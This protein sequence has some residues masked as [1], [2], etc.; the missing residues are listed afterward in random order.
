MIIIPN[1]WLSCSIWLIDG[2]LTGITTIRMDLRVMVMKGY[3]TFSKRWNLTIRRCLAPCSRHSGAGGTSVQRC[4]QPIIKA[5]V[6][7]AVDKTLIWNEK[8]F[9]C[10]YMWIRMFLQWKRHLWKENLWDHVVYCLFLC[11]C[12][13][14]YY[15]VIHS[16]RV[17]L[18]FF[19]TEQTKHRISNSCWKKKKKKDRFTQP[20][21]HR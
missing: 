14:W 20:L 5:P 18:H 1:E 8:F 19:Y 21:H 3:S 7:K 9:V 2:T 6:N 16:V 13:F 11:V 10:K 12:A 17:L 4:S 15:G